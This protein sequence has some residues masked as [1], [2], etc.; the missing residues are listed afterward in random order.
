MTD[1]DLIRQLTDHLRKLTSATAT[2]Y[3]PEV[4]ARWIDDARALLADI[5]IKNA[6]RVYE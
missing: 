2:E 3:S 4:R 5:D 6:G 1:Q